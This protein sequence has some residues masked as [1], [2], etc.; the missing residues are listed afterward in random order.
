MVITEVE[1]TR[2]L[3]IYYVVDV[4]TLHEEI[5]YEGGG[6]KNK[7]SEPNKCQAT[8]LDKHRDT[9]IGD[10]EAPPSLPPQ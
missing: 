8:A 4:W 5:S 2:G 9:L 1:I 10:P 7:L 6:G 3:A